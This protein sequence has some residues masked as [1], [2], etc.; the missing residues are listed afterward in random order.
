MGDAN[1]GFW[2][3]GL[4]EPYRKFRFKVQIGS[5]IWWVKSVTQPSVDINTTEYQLGNH[6]LK[7]PGIATWND[8]ELVIVDVGGKGKNYYNDLKKFG[9]DFSGGKGIQ[10]DQ[11]NE[12][13]DFVIKKLN[14]AGGV[15]E[16]WKLKNA[17]LKSIKYSDLD[18]SADDL[19]EV[20]I[21]VAYDSA[22]LT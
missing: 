3:T 9:Y 12:N 5:D 2:S 19:V 13:S 15:V 17:F 7:Y 20:S 8:I 1:G 18:Y 11:Y 16:T 6:K 14:A 4:L 21:T 22:T 10:K